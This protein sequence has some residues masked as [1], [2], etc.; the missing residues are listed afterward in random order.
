MQNIHKIDCI[1]A[2][3]KPILGSTDPNR[4]PKYGE[5]VD[6]AL[7]QH[8]TNAE[9]DTVING[10]RRSL[11]NHLALEKDI[12]ALNTPEFKVI[13]DEH[14]YKAIER[15]YA[16]FKPDVP[17]QPVHFADLRYYPWKLSTNVGAPFATS[18]YWID[19]VN[20]KFD[21]E[22]KLQEY[23]DLFREAHGLSLEPRMIDR[24]MTK[25]NLYNEMF[26]INRKNIH[27]IK[28]GWKTT[29]TGHDL[30]Y[31]NTAFARQ[32]LVRSFEDDKV[33]L[34]FGAPSTL[35]MAE[36][37]FIWPI[38]THLLSQGA[39]S[40]MLWGYET[41]TGG[42]S[43]LYSWAAQCRP[44]YESVVTLDWSRFDKDARHS[45][46][47]DIH[48]LIMRPMFDFNN[49]Y[50]PTIFYPDTR[51]TNP[52]RIENLWSWMT[53]AITSIPLMLPNG[54]LLRFR[55]SGIYSGYFQT[56]ILDSMYNCIMIYT[57]LSRM[58][59]DINNV[60]LK[61]QGDDSITL[62]PYQFV[63]LE[64]SFLPFFTMYANQ[65]FGSQLNLAKSEIHPSLEGAEVLKYRNR[66]SMPYRDELQLLAM[67]RHP[68]RSMSLESLMAR[69][70]GIAYAN[71]GNFTRVYQICEDIYE[72]LASCGFT[73]DPHG[74]PR[75][76]QYRQDYVPG[77]DQIDLSHFPNYFDTVR[78][79]QDPSRD[80][81]TEKHWPRK[82]FI[83][84]P[85][86][87]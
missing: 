34:V 65:Y 13:K 22:F 30:R 68:E 35:L 54:D 47:K 16:I 14:Y 87:S 42:W 40:P 23:R 41:T 19:Y 31:W 17:L 83:G 57:V 82:H 60:H 81:L 51:G 50:H 53:D 64:N 7:K 66:A 46:I 11:W 5:I 36:L 29:S 71:C 80:I 26:F 62:M 72:Y 33:R 67:L 86:K 77:Y 55:H 43:R 10:Y 28:D 27:L 20:Q 52:K 73:P 18:Q 69:S 61:V 8:L 38:Q 58:G 6:H 45:V 3:A 39:H 21:D 74:L 76:L 63:T 25:R 32:H 2:L 12:E 48:A 4:N 15:T 9:L 44:R 1:P 70:I 37:M 84:I 85:G 24:R 78:H 49:G 75:G 59:F 56:Q 79:L